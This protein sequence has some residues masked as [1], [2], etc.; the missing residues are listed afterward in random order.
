MAYKNAAKEQIPKISG[1]GGAGGQP[2][3]NP[4]R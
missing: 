1:I 2:S 3:I 4:E